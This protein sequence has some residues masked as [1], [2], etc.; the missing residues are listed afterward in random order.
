MEK[1][2]QS[3]EKGH[4]D[5]GSSGEADAEKEHNIHNFYDA[6][7]HIFSS[8]A[9]I[10]E[11]L[12]LILEIN[13]QS[14]L[15]ALIKNNNSYFISYGALF[16]LLASYTNSQECFSFIYRKASNHLKENNATKIIKR[17]YVSAEKDGKNFFYSNDDDLKFIKA[18]YDDNG[19]SKH[20]RFYIIDVEYIKLFDETIAEEMNR[21]SIELKNFTLNCKTKIQQEGYFYEFFRTA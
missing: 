3:E 18:C 15:N 20:D 13:K 9:Y 11:F 1:Q 2:S 17:L 14:G 16:Y 5:H 10:L 4:V 7:D 21:S 12:N 19:D 6:I 8:D